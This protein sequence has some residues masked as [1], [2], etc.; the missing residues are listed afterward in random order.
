[1]KV[2]N[3]LPEIIVTGAGGQLGLTLQEKWPQSSLA[4]DYQLSAFTA[5]ELDITDP[6]ALAKTLVGRQVAAMINAA[7]YTAVD[8]AED[9]ANRD[10]A[11]LVNEQGPRLLANWAAEHDAR[12]IHVSTDFVFDGG[13]QRPYTEQ[14]PT[15]PLGVYG[16][17][18]LAGEQAIQQ[19]LDNALIVRTSWLYSPFRNNFVKTMLRLMAERD[20]LAIVA[21]QIGSP[22]STDSLCEF[23]FAALRHPE[24]TGIYHWC[25]GAKISWYDFASKIQELAL[26]E[27]LLTREITLNPIATD[28][29]P[30]AAKRP[31]YSVLSTVRA[32]HDFRLGKQ[33]WQQNLAAVIRQLAQQK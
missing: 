19:T 9:P 17:S 30:T 16:A 6:D 24:Q 22:T 11:F 1:M 32:E 5:A 14:D 29:Y 4:A 12:M 21:D 7:A 33:D 13:Q 15:A 20:Q 18:K 28:A 10:S 2:M 8:A 23:I 31:P 26:A 3:Q 25:D 27:G